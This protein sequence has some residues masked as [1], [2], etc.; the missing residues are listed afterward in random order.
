MA[1][2]KVCHSGLTLG[3]PPRQNDHEREKRGD[4]AGWSADSSRRNVEFLRCVRVEDLHGC[5]F[6]ITLTVRD[7]QW[8]P[9]SGRQCGELS[10]NECSER[11]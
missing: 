9:R 4:V 2:V 8:T 7:C 3:T 5:G 6:G 11:A 10:S 1:V